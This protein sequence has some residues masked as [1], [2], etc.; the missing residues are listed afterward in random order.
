W[1]RWYALAVRDKRWLMETFGRSLF[2]LAC[3]SAR[4]IG[5]NAPVL[6]SEVMVRGGRHRGMQTTRKQNGQA[7]VELASLLPLL[8]IILL[9][10]LDLGRAFHVHMAAANAAH[11]G[12]MYAQQVT[13]PT[14]PTRSNP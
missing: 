13:D 7:L 11:V 1:S 8:P 12:V 10:C 2:Q 9:G 14:D 4:H 6:I 5:A 3:I